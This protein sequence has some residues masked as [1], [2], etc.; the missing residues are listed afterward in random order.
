MTV[1][2]TLPTLP[3]RPAQATSDGQASTSTWRGL[4]VVR[5]TGKSTQQNHRELAERMRAHA[6]S[7][8]GPVACI[9]VMA[10]PGSTPPDE[11][12]RREILAALGALGPQLHAMAWVVEGRGAL[13]IAARA[14][15]R[16]VARLV[17]VA[18]PSKVS[19]ELR[20]AIGWALA[21]LGAIGGDGDRDGE[22]DVEAACEALLR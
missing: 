17:P 22:V 14:F 20:A 11:P 19:G 1:P 21:Q 13:Q 12:A 5:V 6:A 4:F 15:L 2:A 9:V 3:T 16:G 8:D 10:I 7:H 18:C